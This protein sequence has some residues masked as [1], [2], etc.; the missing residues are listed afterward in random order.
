[1]S[2]GPE[3][4]PEM[5]T[6]LLDDE[7]VQALFRDI[8]ALAQVDEIIVKDRPGRVDDGRQFALEDVARLILAREVRGVQIRYRH[9]GVCWWDTLMCVPEGVKLVR[10]RHEFEQQ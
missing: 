10:I 3:H 5:R 7:G 9:D 4:L 6:G 8:G 1:M 2:D